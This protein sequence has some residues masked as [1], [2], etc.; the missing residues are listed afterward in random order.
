M[1]LVRPTAKGAPWPFFIDTSEVTVSAYRACVMAGRCKAATRIVLTPAG[2]T[3]IG[4]LPK[5][6]KGTSLE[7]LA[8]AWSGRCN[9]ERGQD[10]QPINCVNH[11]TAVDY[12]QWRGKRLPTRAEWLA[13][14]TPDPPAR[15][16]WGNAKPSC[17]EAC[18]GR[19]SL[20]LGNKPE[21]ASCAV[22]VHARDRT[23]RGLVDMAANLSEWVSD[24][25]QTR[26]GGPAWRRIMGGNFLDEMPGLER[27]NE[28]EGPP[29]TAHVTIGF[30]CAK[31]APRPPQPSSSSELPSLEATGTSKPPPTIED[32]SE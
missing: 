22:G 31:N 17:K 18:F 10:R 4:A 23:S 26:L 28:R 14:A 15:F 16:V 25:T 27:T 29:V 6:S 1:V 3:A 7:Q 5:E 21:I 2:A 11:G 30:R 13:A 24:S 32:P 8:A 19:N 9:A 12:C 20:C